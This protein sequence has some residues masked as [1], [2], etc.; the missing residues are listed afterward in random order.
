MTEFSVHSVETAPQASKP[1][2]EH[3]QKEWGFIPTL[4]GILAESPA[5]L[6]AYSDLFALVKTS[7]FSPAEQQVVYLTV[8]V[9]HGCEYCTMG[10]T[11]L[12]RAVGLDEPTIQALRNHITLVDRRLEALR[13]FTECVVRERGHAGDSA[14]DAF[15]A[16]GFTKAQVLEVVLVIAT[17]TISN[18]VNHLTH[19]PKE[20]FMSD[21]AFAWT[22]PR[23]AA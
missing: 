12:A 15:I 9:M 8:N 16:A 1:V 23:K 7:S 4:H 10:H 21:P 20:A 2:L 5:T 17:K 19:T 18:Y 11:Y 22:A 13:R 6:E 14:V 3:T